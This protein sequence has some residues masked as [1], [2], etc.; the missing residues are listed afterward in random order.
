MRTHQVSYSVGKAGHYLLHVGLRGQS[1]ILPGSPFALDVQP[2]PAHAPSTCIPPEL[3][4]LQTVVGTTGRLQIALNDNMG[5][6]CNEISRR[7]HHAAMHVSVNSTDVI[8]SCEDPQDGTM[9]VSWTGEKRGSYLLDICI[10]GVHVQGSPTAIEMV[11]AEV[12]VS[13]C[14]LF[15][16]RE[17]VAGTAHKLELHCRDL[18][19]NDVETDFLGPPCGLVLL[20]LPSSEGKH[21]DK[22]AAAKLSK[23]ERAERVNTLP[24]IAFKGE[25]LGSTYHLSYVP[26]EAGECE[27]HM[28][29]DVNVSGIRSFLPGCPFPLHVHAGQPNASGSFIADV[30]LTGGDESSEPK[31][32]TAGDRLLLKVQ[33]RDEFANNAAPTAPDREM[34]A[35]LQTPLGEQPLILKNAVHLHDGSAEHPPEPKKG[36]GKKGSVARMEVSVGLYELVSQ[37]ELT[38]KGAHTAV[39]LLHGSPVCGSPVVFDVM[40]GNAVAAKSFLEV[41]GTPT[42][43][44]PCEVLLHLVDKFGNACERGDVRVEAKVF[45]S[46]ATDVEV[47]DRQNGMYTLT[48]VAYV[49]GDYKVQCRVENM[50][51]A[52]LNVKMNAD[53]GSAPGTAPPLAASPAPAASAA[54]PSTA[55]MQPQPPLSSPDHS[56]LAPPALPPSPSPLGEPMD[57][58]ATGSASAKKASSEGKKEKGKGK[59]AKAKTK[60]KANVEGGAREA[61]AKPQDLQ[62]V[63]GPTTPDALPTV[64][65]DAADLL[66]GANSASSGMAAPSEL[67]AASPSMSK[68]AK[69][70]KQGVKSK[71]SKKERASPVKAG[72]T[73]KAEPTATD[74]P[75]P[76][77]KLRKERK[78]L[79]TGGKESGFAS[80]VVGSTPCKPMTPALPTAESL[81]AATAI[82]VD[83]IRGGLAS[84][85]VADHACADSMGTGA[86]SAIE[87]GNSGN[88]LAKVELSPTPP[89]S[90]QQKTDRGTTDLR[91]KMLT[92]GF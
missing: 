69:A 71:A 57:L 35:F 47:L 50:E 15:A 36:S 2:G 45:G 14:E 30:N 56:L 34:R 4:P 83:P 39:I 63:D 58:A 82:S 59:S 87:T 61:V 32:F 24:S 29:V 17:A 16:P 27:L 79:G 41:L 1:A 90:K 67:A 52:T 66:P 18:Y 85:N 9:L 20:A 55:A 46:K 88:A 12:E 76:V 86:L 51:L 91:A 26:T 13:R 44:W 64:S 80:S 81:P 7:L 40:H 38:V 78:A 73:A 21:A 22:K 3:L 37:T 54:T 92:R 68:R 84:N 31:G 60:A 11:P 19:G 28:W 23:E 5:N 89:K 48:F 65:V 53:G 62:V 33:L 77:A 75:K 74:K 70:D 6:R 25:W 10:N 42:I 72:S 8:A 43:N 49:P